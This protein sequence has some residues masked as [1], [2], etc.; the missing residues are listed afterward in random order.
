MSM[1]DDKTHAIKVKNQVMGY[2]T[3]A[4]PKHNRPLGQQLRQCTL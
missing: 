4:F 2:C 1:E 3:Q